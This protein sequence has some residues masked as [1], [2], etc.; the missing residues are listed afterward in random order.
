MPGPSFALVKGAECGE[1]RQASASP[2]TNQQEMKHETQG[3][4]DINK[5]YHRAGNYD[6][7]VFR[8]RDG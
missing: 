7:R 8:T 5:V 4:Q 1:R 6:G 3:R 2:L